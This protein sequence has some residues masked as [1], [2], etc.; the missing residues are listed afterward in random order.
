MEGRGKLGAGKSRG[1]ENCGRDVLYKKNLI[2][3]KRN[4]EKMEAM[5]ERKQNKMMQ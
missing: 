5:R 2:S 3:K 1:R 4:E